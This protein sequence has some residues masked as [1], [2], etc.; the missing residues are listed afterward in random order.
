VES[1]KL[2]KDGRT[3]P[4]LS[5]WDQDPINKRVLAKG[6][7]THPKDPLLA[8]VFNRRLGMG[9]L[10]MLQASPSPYGQLFCFTGFL[11]IMQQPILPRFCCGG[12]V[13]LPTE[14][15]AHPAARMRRTLASPAPSSAPAC[16]SV[17]H[18]PFPSPPTPQFTTS[19]TFYVQRERRLAVSSFAYSLH[20]IFAHGKASLR[21]T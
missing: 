15:P 18:D 13:V 19:F 8:L 10:P 12:P 21:K 11:L 20:A 1:V 14:G 5:P 4:G 17:H 2:D 3:L 7:Q 16:P 6:M 9:V